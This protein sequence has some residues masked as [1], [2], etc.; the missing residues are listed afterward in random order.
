MEGTEKDQGRYPQW[1]ASL[2][3]PEHEMAE[4]CDALTVQVHPAD[5]SLDGLVKAL[6]EIAE[7]FGLRSSAQ[8]AR[9]AILVSS[10][11]PGSDPVYL[12][13][14]S[15]EEMDSLIDQIVAFAKQQAATADLIL[16]QTLAPTAIDVGHEMDGLASGLLVETFNSRLTAALS[17][18]DFGSV[19]CLPIHRVIRLDGLTACADWRTASQ[20]LSSLGRR[21]RISYLWCQI[22]DLAWL[23]WRA[24][25]SEL[26]IPA[27]VVAT[28][29]DG[30]LWP[31]TI[32]EDGV[33]DAPRSQPLRHLSHRLLRAHLDAKR[34]AGVLVVGVSKNEEQA[35]R[36]AIEAMASDLSLLEVV[37]R[38]DIDKVAAL[39]EVLC[40]FD[41]VGAD[42]LIFIDD[43]P[44]QQERVRL[45]LPMALVPSVV[46]PPLL[47]EDVLMQL[48][49]LAVT[50]ITGADRQRNEYYAAKSAGELIPEIRCIEDPHDGVTLTRLAQLHER[51][52]QFNMT[53]PRRTATDLAAI[54]RDPRWSLVAFEVIYHG[55]ELQSEIVG[56]AEIEY[57]VDGCRLDSFLASCRLLWAGTQ[58]RMFDIA[59]ATAARHG[60]TTMTVTWRPN[61]R[62]MAFAGWFEDQQWAAHTATASDGSRTSTGTTQVRDGDSPVDLLQV[63]E[64]HLDR[65]TYHTP[66][67]TMRRQ[68]R[69]VDRATEIFVP[70]AELHV[71]LTP[72]DADVVRAIFSIDPFDERDRGTAD[73]ADL[74]A[75]EHLV[76]RSQFVRFLRD[77]GPHHVRDEQWSSQFDIDRRTGRVGCLPDA[78]PLPVIVPVAWAE[79]YAAWVGARLPTEDEWEYL[80]RGT[81]G[82]WY[83]WGVGLPAPPKL[84]PR[85][86]TPHDVTA[87]ADHPS[88]FGLVG[89]V[90]NLWQWCA[91]EYRGHAPYR[92][93]DTRS[94]EYFLRTTVRPLESADRCGHQV[95]FRLVRN[96]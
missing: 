22:V 56:V 29:L 60:A 68:T 96:A 80:A 89:L 10:A 16:V 34:A 14:A 58:R 51:T 79:R 44:A 88:P 7:R 76:T 5:T 59:R 69:T 48:P 75:D 23:H 82:R 93:G 26:G 15:L 84:A 37:A 54:A 72:E 38:P 73:I 90:G 77:T 50:S 45:A 4:P 1:L 11:W 83:P 17:A 62:N 64:R 95:G 78:G 18:D 91:G 12:G 20:S 74:W 61:G 21:D 47:I 24:I 36:E 30:V 39:E 81:D 66:S 19:R 32:A 35:A 86:S 94:N 28:D 8:P 31:G 57:A 46:S 42:R 43:T 70:A 92:G 52:N 63:L 40:R 27:K 33:A 71:G 9:V 41:G 65:R 85:G 2:E 55:A 13:R 67:G 25:A 6:S 49:T 53:S 3:S 87:F